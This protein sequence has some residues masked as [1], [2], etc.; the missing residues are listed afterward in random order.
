MSILYHISKAN[1]VIDP[2]SRLSKRSNTHVEK[3]KRKNWPKMC[4]NLHDLEPGYWITI[5]VELW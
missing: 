4:T 1:V 5:K 3:G 2:M